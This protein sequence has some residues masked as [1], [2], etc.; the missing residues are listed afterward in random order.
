MTF[1][2]FGSAVYFSVTAGGVVTTAN[3]T[4]DDGAGNVTAIG[5]VRPGNGASAGGHMYS[6][7]G[8]PNIAGS[9]AGDYY[10]RTDT[11]STANQRIY[12]ATAANTWSGIV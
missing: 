10:F 5:S 12:V 7:S 3:N 6:G 1:N 9:V 11:P 2:F 4:L 8:A